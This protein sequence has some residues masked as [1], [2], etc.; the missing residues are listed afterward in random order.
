MEDDFEAFRRQQQRNLHALAWGFLGMNV[1]AIG[2]S[3]WRQSWEV[4]GMSIWGLLC[5]IYLVMITRLARGR[6]RK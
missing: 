1:L 6:R 5:S 2:I 3:V 4:T